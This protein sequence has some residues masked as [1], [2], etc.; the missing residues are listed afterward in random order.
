MRD[1][2]CNE[3]GLQVGY[4]TRIDMGAGHGNYWRISRLLA[5]IPYQQ[6]LHLQSQIPLFTRKQHRRALSILRGQKGLT[7]DMHARTLAPVISLASLHASPGTNT[8]MFLRKENHTTTVYDRT[9]KPWILPLFEI[10]PS[11][12]QARAPCQPTYSQSSH[13]GKTW[14]SSREDY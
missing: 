10:F 8:A 4:G 3:L 1:P 14:T 12:P 11:F 6:H 13:R 2:A 5:S 9:N 7:P